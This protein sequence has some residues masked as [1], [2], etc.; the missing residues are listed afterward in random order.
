[1][2]VASQDP[3]IWSTVL[4][5]ESECDDFAQG[6]ITEDDLKLNMAARIP[7]GPSVPTIRNQP[8]IITDIASGT[9]PVS[10]TSTVVPSLASVSVRQVGATLSWVSA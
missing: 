4:Q 1:L 3:L 6:M 7:F 9:M 2:A 10:G 5:I 8:V